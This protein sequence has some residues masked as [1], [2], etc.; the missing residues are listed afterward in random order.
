MSSNF[1]FGKSLWENVA[2]WFDMCASVNRMHWCARVRV[3]TCMR[4]LNRL[5]QIT[6]QSA[7]ILP[8]HSILHCEFVNI[9]FLA[10]PFYRKHIQNSIQ[11]AHFPCTHQFFFASSYLCFFSLDVCSNQLWA[12]ARAH[13]HKY[14]GVYV[15]VFMRWARA[16]FFSWYT[17]CVCVCVFH[18]LLL[19][20]SGW[21]GLMF[22][23]YIKR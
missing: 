16:H 12:W 1:I 20:L 3:R 23:L 19:F 22:V 10:T 11:V 7:T 6:R 2:C 8:C 15:C 21:I 5:M 18:S 13:T 4:V 14:M 17:I 9:F